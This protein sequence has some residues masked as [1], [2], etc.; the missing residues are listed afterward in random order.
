[1]EARSRD[2]QRARGG[3]AKF[4]G[5]GDMGQTRLKARSC[6][7]GGCSWRASVY[8]NERRFNMVHGRMIV[9]LQVAQVDTS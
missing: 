4:D 7:I 8:R 6:W 5:R 3:A 9:K 2:G 1:M